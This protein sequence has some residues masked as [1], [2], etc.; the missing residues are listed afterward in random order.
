MANITS[1]QQATLLLML[2]NNLELDFEYYDDD[3]RNKKETEEPEILE[4]IQE[5]DGED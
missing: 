1:T 3:A 2:E 4:E 5:K